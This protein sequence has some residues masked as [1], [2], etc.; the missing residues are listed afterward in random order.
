LWTTYRITPLWRV[1]SGLNYRGEQNPDG[2]RTKIA[3]A[4]TTVDAMAEY[5]LNDANVIKFNV[6]NLTNKLYADSLYRGFY[7]P[8]APRRVELSWKSMF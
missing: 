2:A 7:A 1:G 6:S 3:A 5:T 4:F 8:G